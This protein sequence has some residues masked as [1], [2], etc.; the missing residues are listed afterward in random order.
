VKSLSR[1]GG[2]VPAVKQGGSQVFAA[3]A[4]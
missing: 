2:L 4:Q 1:R 3:L